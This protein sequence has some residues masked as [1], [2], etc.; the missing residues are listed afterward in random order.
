MDESDLV[1][2]LVGPCKAGKST[3]QQGLKKHGYSC[4]HIAQEH[5]FTPD[6]WKKITNPDILIYLDIAYPQTLERGLPNWREKDFQEQVHRLRHARQN[7][8]LYI[9]TGSSSI[10]QTLHT[11]LEYLKNIGT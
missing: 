3:L 8:D 11:A 4:R 9:H 7:A 2:G 10:E 6:M 1:I 5:S